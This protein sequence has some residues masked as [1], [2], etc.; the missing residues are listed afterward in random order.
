MRRKDR[1]VTDRKEIEEIIKQCKVCHIAMSD[2]GMPYVIP[3]NFGYR[4][5]GDDSLELYFHSALNGRK[6][7]I[8]RKNNKVCFEISYVG[9]TIVSEEVCRSGCAYASVIGYGEV[10]FLEDN[11]DKCNGLSFLF[12][13]QTGR[14][15][16]FEKKQAKSVCVFKLVSKEYTGK[17]RIYDVS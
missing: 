9:E 12:A 7:D 15:M 3:L 16:I 10:T 6:L 2:D 1:E 17:R 8:L 4:F 5:I 11:L 14:E 13:H